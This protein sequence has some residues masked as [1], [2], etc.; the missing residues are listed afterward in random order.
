[1]AAPALR[2]TPALRVAILDDYQEVALS[3]ADWASLGAG[4]SVQ[5]FHEPLGT[6]DAAA[7]ALQSFDIIVAMR[8]RTPFPRSLLSRLPS[9]KL[10]VTT[11]RR[12]AAIDI[13][14]AAER[15][16]PVSGTATLATPPVELTWGLI[17]ALARKIPQESAA[18]RGGA[19][20]TTIGV[21]L[22]GKTLGVIGLGRLGS[23]VAR[24]GKAFGMEVVAWSQH[25][26]ADVTGPL[27]VELVDKAA[28]FRRSDFVTI[29]LVL[30]TRTRGL[31]GE[32][33]LAAMKPTAFL[34]NTARG[35]IVDE[36]AL[37]AAL[38][39]RRIA[40]AGLD[41]Y[42]EEPLPVDHPIRRLDNVVLTPHVGYVTVENYREAYGDA[43]ENIRSFLAGTPLR[44]IKTE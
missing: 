5:A 9:L 39:S 28:I 7:D 31:V 24:I 30:G 26:T 38:R 41:V 3:M 37:M 36:A 44:I 10:L 15:G 33:E 27:G 35:P 4:V 22:K 25:L 8:E 21:G 17:L 34:I 19:W 42:D 40:G 20:Q 11:G 13:A 29:H 6:E 32:A 43:V 1:V 16:V 12:N 23:E 2:T 14:A 18:M